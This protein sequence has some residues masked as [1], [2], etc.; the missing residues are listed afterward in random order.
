MKRD[1]MIRSALIA[2]G[3]LSLSACVS[4]LPEST[5]SAVYRLSSPAPRAWS[6]TEW[7]VIEVVPPLAPS[8][9]AGDEIALQMEDHHIAYMAGA[10]WI[11]PAPRLL[12][13]LIVDTF[14]ASDARLAPSL[15][16][17]GVRADYELRL[18]LR[19]FE[20][21]YDNGDGNAPLVRVRINARLVAANGRH[22]VGSSDF[23]SE[24]RAS[25]NR[26]G[27]IVAAFDQ[28]ST[29]VSRDLA[30][31]TADGTAAP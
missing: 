26:I 6:G 30:T 4:L 20:A 2:F 14:N 24:V 9:L 17:D 23:V 21:I 12:Q 19:E 8:G 25:T 1:W 11:A 13:S 18:D 22:F 10:R 5:P 3:A 28:A 29:Q 31:W 16:D 7:T 15:P 27:A